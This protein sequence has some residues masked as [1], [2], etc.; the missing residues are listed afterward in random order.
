MKFQQIRS[1]TAIVTFANKRFLI[2]PWLAK[3]DTIAPIPG[4]PN[5]GLRSPINDLVLPISEIV[6]VDAVIATH[7]HFD[8]FDEVAAQAI[9]KSMP[10]FAQDKI[11]AHTLEG[12]GF[13]DV[14]ILGRPSEFEGVSLYKT[15]CCHAT[16][17]EFEK[18]YSLVK[19]R[20]EACG[21]V[22][23]SKDEAKRLYLAGDTVWFEGV[24]EAINEFS[25]DVIVLNC[26]EAGIEGFGKIIMGLSDI[27][28]VL[29]CAPN[30][31]VI[32]SHMDNVGHARL[33]RKD[34]RAYALSHN[35]KRLLIPE[36]GEICQF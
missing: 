12:Y 2:D 10:I 13:R 21:V 25:P 20:G 28:E 16:P 1:A 29:K 8:H 11:D 18:L 33:W 35:L 17:G 30:A 6:D 26:A 22:F 9:D 34:I 3:K 19:M 7:L 27:G 5:P 15:R 36:D 23:Q 14:R 24:S 4:S 31:T 32:A